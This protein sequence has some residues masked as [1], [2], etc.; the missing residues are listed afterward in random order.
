LAAVQFSMPRPPV[1]PVPLIERDSGAAAG[2]PARG[3]SRHAPVA[4][5]TGARTAR[6]PEIARDDD[7]VIIGMP[8]IE[9][10]AAIARRRWG[11]PMR[12]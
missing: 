2:V 10:H 3:D 9:D 5:T 7:V 11:T 1:P 6:L 12:S 8:Q 4:H